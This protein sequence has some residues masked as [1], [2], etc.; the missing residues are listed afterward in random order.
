MSYTVDMD[1]DSTLP[2]GH[3]SHRRHVIPRLLLAGTSPVSTAWIPLKDAQNYGRRVRKSAC[4][5]L[6]NV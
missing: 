1:R 2:T 5:Q 3:G 4:A 6:L